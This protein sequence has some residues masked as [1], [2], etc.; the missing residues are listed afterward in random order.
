MLIVWNHKRFY[1]RI[2]PLMLCVVLWGKEEVVHSLPLFQG[3]TV[4]DWLSDTVLTVVRGNMDGLV[5]IKLGCPGWH[6]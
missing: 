6:I 4:E 5:G 2:L 3:H 1:E